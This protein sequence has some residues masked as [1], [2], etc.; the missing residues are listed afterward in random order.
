MASMV[1][2][3]FRTRELL[4]T[5]PEASYLD[6]KNEILKLQEDTLN[7]L[8]IKIPEYE[9]PSIPSSAEYTPGESSRGPN[10]WTHPWTSEPWPN[11]YDA[12]GCSISQMDAQMVQ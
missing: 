8:R 9:Q 6:V 1:D 10:T 4:I 2:V 11:V 3:T 7:K 12:Q 5:N